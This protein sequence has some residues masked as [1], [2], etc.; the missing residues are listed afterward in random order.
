MEME[1]AKKQKHYRLKPINLRFSIHLLT[2]PLNKFSIQPASDPHIHANK[3]PTFI[4][5]YTII[6]PLPKQKS[7]KTVL[8][9]VSRSFLEFP[10]FPYNFKGNGS[11]DHQ[12]IQSCV[13]N[14][15]GK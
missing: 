1:Y 4:A 13:Q 15:K 5:D 14:S 2:C 6:V 3:Y 12:L 9:P 7:K 10:A 11:R 8:R